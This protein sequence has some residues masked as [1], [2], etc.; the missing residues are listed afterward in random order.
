M[1]LKGPVRDSS[2]CSTNSVRDGRSFSAAHW[3]APANWFAP[4]FDDSG[5]PYATVYSNDVVG[6]DNKPAFM[7]FQAV[8]DDPKQD[9]QFIWSSNLVL[10]NLVLMRKTVE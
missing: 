8:F 3:Q 5:W 4:D 7:N 1:K 6:V 2:A 9:A 10:D